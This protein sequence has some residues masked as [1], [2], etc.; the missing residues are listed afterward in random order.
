MFHEVTTQHLPELMIFAVVSPEDIDPWHLPILL[1]LEK[2]LFNILPCQACAVPPA[3]T[4][5]PLLL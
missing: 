1:D 5:Y 4:L 2:D 3:R